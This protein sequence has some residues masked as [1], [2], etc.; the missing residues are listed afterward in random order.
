M[1]RCVKCNRIIE[2][3]DDYKDGCPCGSKIFVYLN[4]PGGNGGGEEL[5]VP[6]KEARVEKEEA[7]PVAETAP[8]SEAVQAGEKQ[9]EEKK[10]E[11]GAEFPAEPEE[12][13]KFEESL[14]EPEIAPLPR[15]EN[16]DKR[17]V[18]LE[19]ENI[20]LVETGIYEIDVNSLSNNP[21]VVKD[22]DGVYYV[23]LPHFK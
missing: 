21:V 6:K 10:N 7:K 19:L 4:Q 15:E 22:K 5:K 18:I 20:R 9:A 8:N 1:H 13:W 3:L 16:A 11:N 12:G 2:S 23:K 17:T 14:P